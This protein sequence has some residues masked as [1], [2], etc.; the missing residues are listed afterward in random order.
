MILKCKI[1][2]LEI[3]EEETKVIINEENGFYIGTASIGNWEDFK[4]TLIN[5]NDDWTFFD[6]LKEICDLGIISW[7]K[8]YNELLET[9]ESVLCEERGHT[10]VDKDKI[11]SNYGTIGDYLFIVN[12]D[13]YYID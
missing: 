9:C 8:S 7:A 6:T 13:N 10:A 2:T 3:I 5:T 11:Y 4:D 1:G 12:Y